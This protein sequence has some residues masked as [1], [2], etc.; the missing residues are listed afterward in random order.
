M[1]LNFDSPDLESLHQDLL[2]VATTIGPAVRAVVSKGA[3][4]IKTDAKQR[5]T[6]QRVGNY[7][8]RYARSISY[9]LDST[10]DLIEAVIGPESDKPQGGMGAAIEYGSARTPPL[11]HLNPALDAEDPK[12]VD[13]IGDAAVK[14]LT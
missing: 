6:D 14:A 5:F 13:A 10:G 12:A 4:N 2:D 7:L 3:L 11:P 1:N 9:D 8:P